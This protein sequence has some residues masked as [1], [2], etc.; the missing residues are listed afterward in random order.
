MPSQSLEQIA[1]NLVASGKGI[2]AA[3]ESNGTMSKRLEAVNVEPSEHTRRAYRTAMFSSEGIEEYISG[4][5]LF[6][7]TIRQKM[8]DGTPIPDYLISKGI[9][10]G[11]KVDTGAKPLSWHE[12][13]TVTE[14]L[15]GLRG[16][17]E[18]YYRM[19]ARFAKWRAVIKIS[20][21]LP[22]A[23]AISVNAHAL[24]RYAAICQEQ[25][26]VPI[27]EPEV[28]MSGPHG[29]EQCARTTSRILKAVYSECKIQGVNL[30]GTILKPNMVLSGAEAEKEDAESVGR[31]TAEVLKE[32]VPQEVAGVAFLSGGQ[33]D[34]DATSHLNETNL[35]IG[36]APWPLTF[37]FGRALLADALSLWSKSDVEG[38][39]ARLRHRS[40][41][42]ALAAVG[43]WSSDL[44]V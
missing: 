42:N 2:L 23:A 41:M 6:D 37:S 16:R 4:V 44:E 31:A 5:I 28:L 11:I 12:G 7:E 15:D 38:A 29:L 24:A 3:D 32:T 1:Q 20:G 36:N 26:I 19:G 14:G 13:E 9:I 30:K 35:T 40:K 27:I 25:G 39:Q 18:E 8:D 10:P 43:A 33:S 17:C 21:D 22:S 34:I